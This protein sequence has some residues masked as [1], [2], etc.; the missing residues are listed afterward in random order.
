MR[1]SVTETR[2]YLPCQTAHDIDSWNLLWETQQGNLGA[3]ADIYS[4]YSANIYRYV[5]RLQRD[6]SLAEDFTNETF[7]RAL[8]RIDSLVYRGRSVEAWLTAIARNIVL[9]H[10]RNGYTRKEKT[11]AEPRLHADVCTTPEIQV[12]DRTTSHELLRCVSRLP[13][14]QRDCI[15]LRFLNELSVSETAARMG[16]T[17]GAVR[18]LQYRA[19]RALSSEFD[20]SYADRKAGNARWEDT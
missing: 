18:A 4:R 6:R 2:D 15:V 14:A 20:V 16:R 7:M 3:F 1:Q 17:T 11:F 12:L 19:I 13:A 10:M 9:D 5:L 8:H